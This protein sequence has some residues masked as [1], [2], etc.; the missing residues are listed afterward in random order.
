MSDS[1]HQHG[2]R[3]GRLVA[4]WATL[5]TMVA[6]LFTAQPAEA[7]WFGLL[8][9]DEGGQNVTFASDEDNLDHRLYWN[10]FV[11]FEQYDQYGART[12]LSVSELTSGA[13]TNNTDIVWFAASLPGI[14]GDESCR[15]VLS[16]G[17]CDRARIRF[18][19]TMTRAVPDRMGWFLVCHEFGHAYGFEDYGN[20]D[21]MAGSANPQSPPADGTL[22]GHMIDH[23][24]AYY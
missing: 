22:S 12:D 15:V 20:G 2:W 11:H 6:L 3:R 23:I 8:K 4:A 21:C 1:K 14:N 5:M 18:D 24:N 16:S 13:W 7:D 17:V 9:V 19:E 10:H